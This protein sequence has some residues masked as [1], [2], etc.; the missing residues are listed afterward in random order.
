MRMPIIIRLSAAFAMT[1]PILVA[2]KAP[3]SVCEA[4]DSPV[5]HEELTIR[6]LLTGEF[7]HG[8]FL[9]DGLGTDPCPGWRRRFLTAPSV[10]GLLFQ[11]ARGVEITDKEE[12]LDR[13]FIENLWD[14]SGKRPVKQVVTVRGVAVR[15]RW[16]LIFRRAD[17]TYFSS[18]MGDPQAWIPVKFVVKSIDNW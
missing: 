9:S 7:H 6:G 14:V 5:G 13:A 1:V 15:D 16:S 2:Q 11:S 3:M 12:Q 4:L 18:N 17:G 8:F 10:L